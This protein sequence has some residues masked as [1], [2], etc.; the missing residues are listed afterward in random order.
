MST[1][2]ERNT[3]PAARGGSWFNRPR[4]AYRVSRYGHV[5]SDLYNDLGLRLVRRYP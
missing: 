3:R 5:S 2:L 4:L 1:D